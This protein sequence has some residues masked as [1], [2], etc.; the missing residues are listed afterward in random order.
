MEKPGNL[1]MHRQVSP[2]RWSMFAVMATAMTVALVCVGGGLAQ[3]NEK[4]AG[5]IRQY[6][7]IHGNDVSMSGTWD[8]SQEAKI[9]ELRARWGDDFAWF[10]Q[11]GSGYIITDSAVLKELDAAMEP[12]KKVNRMQKDV[13]ALQGRV[14]DMQAKVNAHQKVVNAS[15][16]EVNRAQHLGSEAQSALSRGDEKTTQAAVNRQQAEVNREQA[17]VNAEQEKVNARQGEVNDEQRRASAEIQ[18]RVQEVFLHSVQ[19][20]LARRVVSSE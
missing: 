2:R 18:R 4:E 14:N 11:G 17:G 7:I 9:K 13:N 5:A 15:Q 8:T 16:Q 20:G 1:E 6:A 19:N 3:T 12:Q 10:L